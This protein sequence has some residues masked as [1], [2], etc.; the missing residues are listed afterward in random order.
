MIIV[1][2][3][4]LC[5][6]WALNTYMLW[7]IWHLNDFKLHNWYRTWLQW[8]ISIC[9]CPYDTLFLIYGY[10]IISK[11]VA[12]SHLWFLNMNCDYFFKW[13]EK[14]T[15]QKV[16]LH[17]KLKPIFPLTCLPISNFKNYI[18]TLIVDA[19]GYSA[20]ST[21][22]TGYCKSLEE[23]QH[24]CC[25]CALILW[26]GWHDDIMMDLLCLFFY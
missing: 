6:V 12:S 15:C 13:P 22:T 25:H 24:S 14:L 8:L 7:S 23:V 21:C 16:L 10:I 9:I 19:N 18:D 5:E 17:H 4:F 1:I 11:K 20:Y 3:I 2:D 26:F